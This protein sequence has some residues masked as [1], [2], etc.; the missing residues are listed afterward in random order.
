MQHGGHVGRVPLQPERHAERVSE[1]SAARIA[2]FGSLRQ[3]PQQDIIHGGR[4]IGPPR[5]E[6][7]RWLLQLRVQHRRGLLLRKW[8]PAGQQFEGRARERVLIRARVDPPPLDLFGRAVV[9]RAHE[10]VHSGQ[11]GRRE[12]AL[13]QAE[14]RQ[15]HVVGP[16]NPGIEEHVGRLDIA[17]HQSRGV[18]G[19]ESRR[20]PGD[21][22]G[23]ALGGQRSRLFQERVHVAAWHVAH[24]DEQHPIRLTSLE[25]RDD[26]RIVHRGRG[27][28]FEDEAV[29]ERLVRR[30]GRREDLQSYLPLE[31]LVLGPEYNRHSAPADLLTEAVS[32]DPRT[33][34]EAVHEPDSAGVPVTHRAS[35]TGHPVAP[36]PSKRPPGPP[37]AVDCPP[38]LNVQSD[39]C[40]RIRRRH[41]DKPG[42][43]RTIPPCRYRHTLPR[44]ESDFPVNYA[45]FSGSTSILPPNHLRR[46]ADA[47]PYTGQ[48][49]LR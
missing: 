11:V 34:K 9:E 36:A 26:V 25:H 18:R 49:S 35:S 31:P 1:L 42:Q 23:D 24:R 3:S 5:R 28:R 46:K 29:P 20:D 45:D 48:V 38:W 21:N 40:R 2:L 43:P 33:G 32:G 8:R 10:A 16:A 13:A 6:P 19:V 47:R 30:Q 41:G 22:R 14:V 39:F 37:T 7:R 27:P 17:V 4:E 15:I 12:R 44:S